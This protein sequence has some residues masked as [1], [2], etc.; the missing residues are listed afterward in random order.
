MPAALLPHTQHARYAHKNSSAA[1]RSQQATS[2]KEGRE[3]TECRQGW[4]QR[5]PTRR[6]S[7]TRRRS[8]SSRPQP[9]STPHSSPYPAPSPPAR[10]HTRTKGGQK[11]RGGLRTYVLAQLFSCQRTPRRPTCPSMRHDRPT[12]HAERPRRGHAWRLPPALALP[13][14][15]PTCPPGIAP[16]PTAGPPGAR[17]LLLQSPAECGRMHAPVDSETDLTLAV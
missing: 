13:L 15:A 3:A 16:C 10:T 8:H 11:E 4:R 6:P 5:P 14:M 7:P 12:P 9:P 2:T 1:H 17:T